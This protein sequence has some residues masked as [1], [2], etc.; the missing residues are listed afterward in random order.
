LLGA[1]KEVQS[2]KKSSEVDLTGDGGEPARMSKRVIVL[3]MEKGIQ[4][5]QGKKKQKRPGWQ[6]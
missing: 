2:N 3:T 6:Q 5:M 1:F 4:Q